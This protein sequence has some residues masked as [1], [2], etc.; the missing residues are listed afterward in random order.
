VEK[1]YLHFLTPEA[2]AHA[3]LNNELVIMPT[4]TVYGLAAN[5]LSQEA[6]NKIYSTKKRN[7]ANPLIIHFANPEQVTDHCEV[8]DDFFK[9]AAAFWPG[10]LT[11]VLKKKPNTPIKANS[12]LDTLA[13]RIPSHPLALELIKIT[14][15]PISAPSANISGEVSPTCTDDLS[16]NILKHAAGVIEGGAAEK[17][18]ESTVLDLSVYPYTIL[19]PGSITKK[20]IELILNKQINIRKTEEIADS[21]IKSP[22]IA[23]KHYAPSTPLRI[24]ATDI[25]DSNEALLA[26]GTPIKG[27]KYILNLSES[28]NLEEAAHNLY[29][30]LIKLDNMGFSSIAVMPI[31]YD[32]IGAAINDRL[33]RAA[34]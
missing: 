4:E 7:A 6:V 21:E 20:Q 31:P 33:K 19:R 26:F 16:I 27:A 24:N 12:K 3:L 22:G 10:P 34:S 23:F 15:V 30:F 1:R 5:A 8:D 28:S 18:I 25:K 9:L 14:G 11:L 32:G 2:A 29:H 17:G 13:V